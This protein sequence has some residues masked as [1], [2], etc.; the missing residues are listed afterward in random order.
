MTRHFSNLKEEL[1]VRFEV[2]DFFALDGV[3]FDLIYDYTSVHHGS[4]FSFE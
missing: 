1:S 2:A 4:M 3:Q